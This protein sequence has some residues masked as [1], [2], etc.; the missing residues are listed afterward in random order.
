MSAYR[1]LQPPFTLDFPEMSR[2]E[3]RA[4]FKWF[5]EMTP[6]RIEHLA[7]TVQSSPGFENW[8]ADFSPD[9]LNALGE[10]FATQIETRPRIQQE[11]DAFNAQAPFPIKLS[12]NE[13]TNRTFSL[14]MDIGMY[15]NQVFLRN[16]PGLTWDQ[17]FG[18]KRFIDYGQPVLVGFDGGDIPFNSVR[19]LVTL[20]Y[21]LRDKNL[22]G[23]RLREIYDLRSQRKQRKFEDQAN[24]TYEPEPNRP[25]ATEYLVDLIKR[26]TIDEPRCLNSDDSIAWRAHREAEALADP[27]M[28]DELSQYLQNEGDKKR[29]RAAY[30]ILGKLGQKVRGCDCAS[31]LLSRVPHEENKYVL[32]GLLGALRELP[33]PRRLDLVPVY[34][35]LQDDRWLV[36]HSAIRAL[37]QTD[38]PEAENQL[39]QVLG[40]TSDPN[41]MVCCQSTLNEIGTEKSIP[42]LQENLASKKRDV[43]S[44][45]LSAIKAIQSRAQK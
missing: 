9:S 14:A 24:T 27:G 23:K 29:R 28:V 10:W 30:F 36:R 32:S 17:P 34:S 15:L 8:Q 5:Q 18:G 2:K 12:D 21:G 42:L 41:D 7:S 39:L 19:A 37:V 13:L 20:A 11:I 31:I 45:A 44:S 1:T 16:Y 4:Y 40:A 22:G 43:R 3:L 38:T 33:K 35:L 25:P 6:E 26:M